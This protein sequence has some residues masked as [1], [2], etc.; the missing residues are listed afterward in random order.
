MTN[1]DEEYA[2][3]GTRTSGDD[4]YVLL[5]DPER[6]AFI[7]HQ[8]DSSFDMNLTSTPWD[9]DATS[10]RQSYDQLAPP[11]QIRKPEPQCEVKRVPVRNNIES[12]VKK[13]EKPKKPRATRRE[14]TPEPVEED[15]DDDMIV[16]YPDG[17]PSQRFQSQSTPIFRQEESEESEEDADSEMEEDSRNQDVEALSLPSPVHNS[18]G[19]EPEEEIDELGLEAELLEA[20]ENETHEDGARDDESSESEEE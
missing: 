19:A 15:S 20:L 2:Y 4:Q 12:K 14:P 6:K 10:L 11:R 17:P 18:G 8:I 3:R 5:F 13:T 16:E 1:N 7:L 9:Q